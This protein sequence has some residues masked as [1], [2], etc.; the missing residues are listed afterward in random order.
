ME[1]KKSEKSFDNLK[2]E[3]KFCDQKETLPSFN[4]SAILFLDDQANKMNIIK[5][6]NLEINSPPSEIIGKKGNIVANRMNTPF[7]ED[8][9][10]FEKICIFFFRYK[11]IKSDYSN[12]DS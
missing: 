7:F 5:N 1:K 9:S 3:K 11:L 10:D 12:S 2:Y 6:E 8:Y 4:N